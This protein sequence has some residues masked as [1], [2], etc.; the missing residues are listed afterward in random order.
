MHADQ[1][2][3]ES[4][5]RVE[6]SA[7]DNYKFRM[8]ELQQPLIEW[9]ER[10]PGV[11]QPRGMYERVLAEV[12]SG[13]ADL[14]VSR[15]RAR[16]HWGVPVPG[17]SEHTMYV[18]IEAL[19]NYLTAVGYPARAAAWPA[20]VH[21]VGKDIVRFHAVYWP[22]LLLAA[23]LPLPRQIVAHAHWTVERAKMSKSKGNSVD[24]FSAIDTYGMDAV[25]FFLMRVGGNLATDADYSD[26]MLA[27]FQ[28][29]YLQGQLG[30]LLSRVLAPKIQSRLVGVA[31]DGALPQPRG[32]RASLVALP[33]LFDRHMGRCEI[34]K[35]LAAAFDVVGT[36]NERVQ[37]AAPWAA[38]T[39]LD[40]V[41]AAVYDSVETLR[42][43]GTL[44]QPFMPAPMARLLDL[45]GVP[46]AL[47]TWPGLVDDSGE[48]RLRAAVPLRTEPGKIAPLFPR[49]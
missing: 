46:P 42:T 48:L 16:L 22:A 38:D 12:R 43:V 47:R 2:A 11:I 45:L 28:R 26:A 7:E 29:K 36:A 32:D 25:R 31:R 3:I 27:E 23:G 9:L 10:N 21:V 44:L 14:S 41:H 33:P 37:H 15:P 17:D 39:P 5:Q 20:D 13:L 1:E 30:N 49:V 18:W 34:S 40:V 8:A 35:A 24:P 19:A 4:G 6:W